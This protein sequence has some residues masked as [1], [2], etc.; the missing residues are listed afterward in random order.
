MFAPNYL[1]CALVP[2]VS[3]IETFLFV[4]AEQLTASRTGPFCLFVPDELPDTR[5]L[6]AL[7]V[8]DHA[9]PVFSAVALV[10]LLESGAGQPL[11]ANAESGLSGGDSFTSHDFACGAICGLQVVVFSATRALVFVSDVSAAQATVHTTRC[12]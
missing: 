9:H 2:F 10:Q 5:F 1:P 7:E 8:S 3:A 6:D 4:N 11:T 12:R